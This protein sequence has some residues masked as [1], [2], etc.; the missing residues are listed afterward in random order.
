M[1]G[2]RKKH[3]S[4][5]SVHREARKQLDCES[6][7]RLAIE[8]CLFHYPTLYTGGVPRRCDSYWVVPV[9]LEDPEAGISAAV[10]ELRIHAQTGQVRAGTSAADVVSAGGRWYQEA[11]DARSIAAAP[12]KKR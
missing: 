12:R 4:A 2:P 9:L 8:Y 11:R 7:R 5:S 6:V 3:V 10:G 1:S